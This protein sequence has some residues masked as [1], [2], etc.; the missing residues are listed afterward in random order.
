MKDAKRS[1][2]DCKAWPRRNRII[3]LTQSPLCG[4]PYLTQ[5]ACLDFVRYRCTQKYLL[6]VTLPVL[7]R[8]TGVVVADPRFQ[9]P[10]FAGLWSLAQ[11]ARE[12]MDETLI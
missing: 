12:S 9:K 3:S 4:D 11:S 10:G 1:A 7:L 5:M 2:P 6:T 8:P